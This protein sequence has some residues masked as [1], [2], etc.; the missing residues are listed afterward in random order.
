MKYLPDTNIFIKAA[1][2]YLP[3]SK[4]LNKIIKNKQ[5]IIST[6]VM[7]EFL[8]KATAQEEKTFENLLNEFTV[9]SID[10]EIA[11]IAA[12]YRKASLKVKRGQMLDCFLAAQANINHLT[13]VTNNK[14]DFP[15]R[16]IKIISP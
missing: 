15:M 13:L 11:K 10:R 9:L 16:D 3:E 2:G 7:G 5:I 12:Q 14:S 4:F 6:I 1:K 8:A